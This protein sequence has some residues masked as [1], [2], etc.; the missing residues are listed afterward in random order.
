VSYG[1]G[2][3]TA[4]DA[5][6][7]QGQR[8]GLIGGGAMA[9]SIPQ[10]PPR[11]SLVAEQFRQLEQRIEALHGVIAN[12]SDRLSAVLAPEPPNGVGKE[13]LPHPGVPLAAGLAEAN[14]RL[15]AAYSRLQSILDRVE[16]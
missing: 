6:C 12:L 1:N 15:G 4:Y 8:V 16:L 14:A 10:P 7:E 5:R 2:E 13:A 11:L 9:G 3:T